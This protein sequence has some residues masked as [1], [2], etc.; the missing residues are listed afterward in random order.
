MFFQINV[1][2]E[3]PFKVTGL[4]SAACNKIKSEPLIKLLKGFL[5]ISKNLN[6]S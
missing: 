6:N 5:K 3:A 1:F 2:N 4:Q